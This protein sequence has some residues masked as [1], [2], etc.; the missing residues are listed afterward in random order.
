ATEF[1]EVLGPFR[2]GGTFTR[3]NDVYRPPIDVATRLHEVHDDPKGILVAA[4]EVPAEPLA[5]DGQDPG[6]HLAARELGH[7]LHIVTR[8]P[9]ATA[10]K[11]DD[12]LGIIPLIGLLH[13]L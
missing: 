4:S 3:P 7:H 12:K 11:D 13:R 2:V 6:T 5:A 8:D 10:G 1:I 9:R